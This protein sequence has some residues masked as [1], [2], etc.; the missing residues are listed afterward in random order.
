MIPIAVSGIGMRVLADKVKEKGISSNKPLLI[1]AIALCM[2]TIAI[3][4][5]TPPGQGYGY[6]GIG[7]ILI[8]VATVFLFNMLVGLGNSQKSVI[9]RCI[10]SVEKYTLGIYCAHNL[11]ALPYFKVL[12]HIG[13]PQGSLLD[14][15]I[16]FI[17]SL[18]ISMTIGRLFHGK[19]RGM[20]N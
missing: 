1:S 10:G 9:S 2:L 3:G 18:M 6:N 15:N 4:F 19:L 8:A 16:I 20:V 5:N 13:L 14:A 17:V 7:K 12:E 11:V